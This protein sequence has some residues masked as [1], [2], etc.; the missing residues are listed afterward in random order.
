[1][2]TL[3]RIR[4]TTITSSTFIKCSSKGSKS[5]KYM[6]KMK[7]HEDKNQPLSSNPIKMY[8]FCFG[9]C[10][11][12]LSISFQCRFIIYFIYPGV[13]VLRMVLAGGDDDI[14]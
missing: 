3:Y 7:K 5:E 10:A 11:I 6:K 12:L 8:I 1:M 9:L 13:V 14:I 2:F 4:I